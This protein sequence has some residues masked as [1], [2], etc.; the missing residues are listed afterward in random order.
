MIELMINLV[1]QMS[2]PTA[3]RNSISELG[4]LSKV[5]VFGERKVSFCHEMK[6]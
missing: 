2:E 1:S 6:I 5:K 4:K 3:T